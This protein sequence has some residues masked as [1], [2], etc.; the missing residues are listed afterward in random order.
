MYFKTKNN[1]LYLSYLCLKLIHDSGECKVLLRNI[2]TRLCFNPLC[3][4]LTLDMQFFDREIFR[5][6]NFKQRFGMFSCSN[7][8]NYTTVGKRIM[9]SFIKKQ[10]QFSDILE[11]SGKKCESTFKHFHCALTRPRQLT[12]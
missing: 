8:I 4:R 2:L 3:N 12:L 6:L 7:F 1:N 5:V 10:W 9:C 11:V